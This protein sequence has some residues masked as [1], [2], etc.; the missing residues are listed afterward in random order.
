MLEKKNKMKNMVKKRKTEK[1]RKG[2]SLVVHV[3]VHV[4]SF[5]CFSEWRRKRGHVS[6]LK[7]LNLKLLKL[8]TNVHIKYNSVTLA[9]FCSL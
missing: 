5:S 1:K 3:Y 4:F 6:Q 8:S 9:H 7:G 2:L